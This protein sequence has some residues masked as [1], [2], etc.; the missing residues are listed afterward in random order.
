MN[1]KKAIRVVLDTALT[2]MLV[3]EMFIQFTGE[4]L[5]EVV[6]FAF[7]ATVVLHL[8]LSAAWVK[9]TARNAKEGKMTARRTALAVVG[10]LLAVTMIILG[11][12]SV[13]ISGILSSAGFVWPIGTYAM[14]ATVHAFSS[15]A[16]CALV[17]VHLAMHWVFLASA[18]KVPYN[19]SRRRAIATGV[20]TVA[21][22]GV[23]ALGSTAVG[24]IA[25]QAVSAASTDQATAGAAGESAAVETANASGVSAGSESFGNVS[26]APAPTADTSAPSTDTSAP[27]T[28]APAPSGKSGKSHGKGSSSSASASSSGAPSGSSSTVPSAG[29]ASASAPANE[30]SSGS[31][32]NG[33]SSGSAS[34]SSGPS[35]A[36][37]TSSSSV[38]GICTLCRKQC[39]LS[40]P[41]CDKPYA[42]GLL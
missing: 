6:G 7:F 30:G 22:L 31:T 4:F 29:S 26:D 27:S 12:S 32:G 8:A 14:W 19:P 37:N 36:S 15:Y 28:D 1:G 10:S 9:K 17:V 5:H 3:F 34:P 13:A 23:L 21:A 39:S 16:L 20:N 24:K 33:N 2:L 18:F 40:A 25:P 38:S 42:A 41:K 11:V 35:S